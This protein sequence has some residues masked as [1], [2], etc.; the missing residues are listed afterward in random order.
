MY[1][2][3]LSTLSSLNL[4]LSSSST[5]SREFCRNTR[6]VMDEDDLMWV[7]IK[8]NCHVLISQF[9]GNFDYKTLVIGKFNLFT[10]M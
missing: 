3:D 4:P 6:L 9:H 7:K 2:Q 5:T 1:I 10:G 8:E